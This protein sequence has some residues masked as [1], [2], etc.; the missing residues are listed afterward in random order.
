[1]EVKQEPRKG[2]WARFGSVVRKLLV[3]GEGVVGGRIE[4]R[5]RIISGAKAKKKK[6]IGY[7]VG[8]TNVF[9]P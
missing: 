7:N 5:F 1:M 9:I 3:W 6:N 2:G 4:R 8:L